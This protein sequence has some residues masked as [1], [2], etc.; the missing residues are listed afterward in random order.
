MH[1]FWYT[2]LFITVLIGIT[3]TDAG[4][5]LQHRTCT[6]SHTP[7]APRIDGRP[8]DAAWVHAA[9]VTDFRRV[10]G[11]GTVAA[12]TH[13]RMVRTDQA[14]CILAEMDEPR[15]EDVK[16]H[17]VIWS[18]DRIEIVLDASPDDAA[19]CVFAVDSTGRREEGWFG[20]P[21]YE[22]A[23]EDWS[24]NWTAATWATNDHWYVEIRLPFSM[25]E[26]KPKAGDTWKVNFCRQR[27]PGGMPPVFSA[28]DSRFGGFHF[29]G[30]QLVFKQ[31]P[32]KGDRP[33]I[34]L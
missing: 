19:Y 24:P 28:W 26:A 31:H 2:S 20:S 27:S 15:T 33:C 9:T 4:T 29:A 13:I 7:S 22:D 12:Q 14:L 1:K 6:V 30:S 5:G 8:D 11:T 3:C 10:L 18:S 16:P 34:K 17:S 25:L 23:I 21:D 32:Q